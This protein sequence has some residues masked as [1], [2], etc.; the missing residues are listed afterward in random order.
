MF[1]DEDNDLVIKRIVVDNRYE[2]RD[3]YPVVVK[4]KSRFETTYLHLETLYDWEVEM[5]F[6]PGTL[7]N[8]SV[9]VNI[10]GKDYVI[11][12]TAESV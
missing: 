3:F 1:N 5:K 10:Y 7:H 9:I 2:P 12:I 11:S 4:S 6:W 8:V